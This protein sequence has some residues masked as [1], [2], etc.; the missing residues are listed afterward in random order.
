M[1]LKLAVV[2]FRHNHI[3][4]LYQA[5]Q[6]MGN[7]DVV[8]C[9][10]EDATTRQ[11]L[12]AEQ[13]IE[14]AYTSVDRLLIELECDAIAVGDTYGRRGSLICRALAAGKHVISDKPIC[15]SLAELDE[16]ERL[17]RAHGCRVGCMFDMRDAPQFIGARNLIQNGAIG[18]VH[19]ISFGGQHPLML[20]SRPSWYF[21][22]GQHGGTINDIAVHAIDILPWI[23]GFPFDQ[24]VAARCWN[25][26]AR[27]YPHFEDA[28]QLML[29]MTNGCGVIGDVSYAMPDSAGYSSP[30]Y[31]RM[32]FWGSE[33][34]LETSAVA[35]HIF[36][37]SKGDKV[38]RSEFLPAGTPAGYLHSFLRDIEEMPR[39][40]GLRTP[41][42]L[43][44]AR[45]ALTVQHAADNDLHHVSLRVDNH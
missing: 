1:A 42:V 8:A 31:W 41:D 17:S 36:L 30:L 2:G 15:T 14:F 18:E 29:R 4:D 22:P 23:T 3:L 34:M 7:V 44:A 28:G 16:I 24:I 6:K 20:G 37:I 19:T 32:T 21:E 43:R 40:E 38:G 10:E 13:R 25:A 39:S 12:T 9:C 35:D 5:A 11:R 45:I 26:F 33:G 27:Q